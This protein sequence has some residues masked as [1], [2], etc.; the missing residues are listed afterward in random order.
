[1]EL[2]RKLDEERKRVEQLRREMEY[3]R[4][5]EPMEV[6]VPSSAPTARELRDFP[7]LRPAIQGKVAVIPGDRVFPPPE[8]KEDT[9]ARKVSARR[10]RGT[11]GPSW[12]EMEVFSFTPEGLEVI[13]EDRVATKVAA[14]LEALA[15]RHRGE[16]VSLHTA[17]A[18]GAL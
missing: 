3:H 17:P 12:G 14:Q 7:A 4:E 11:K 5:P 8:L 13:L 2:K 9:E 18:R 1:V 10:K 16:G 6:E 15:H